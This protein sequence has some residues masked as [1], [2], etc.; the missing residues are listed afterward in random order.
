MNQDLMDAG[1]QLRRGLVEK[2]DFEIVNQT[3]HD[4]IK[5]DKGF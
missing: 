1:G 3:I 4:L 5:L 2:K